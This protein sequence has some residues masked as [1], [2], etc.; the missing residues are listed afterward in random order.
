MDYKKS[1]FRQM[2][3]EADLHLSGNCPLI[4]DEAIVWAGEKIK[5]LERIE[6]VLDR[7]FELN[8]CYPGNKYWSNEFLEACGPNAELTGVAKRSPS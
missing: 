7:Y 4:E 8:G 2:V 6:S 1:Q 5:K 3:C